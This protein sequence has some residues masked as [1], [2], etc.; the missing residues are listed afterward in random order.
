M[1]NSGDA[2]RQD[3]PGA[4]VLRR[5]LFIE[6]P[7][8]LVRDIGSFHPD[9]AIPIP[10]EMGREV[11]R[12][13]P[14]DL[15]WESMVAGMLRLLAWQPDHERAAYYRAFVKAVR[16]AIL[17]ELS[18]AGIIKARNKDWEIAEEIFRALAGL[19]P[20]APEPLIDLAVMFEDRA[21]AYVAAEKE[22]LAEEMD[23][24]A[25]EV[26]KR[27]LSMEP[28]FAPA[29]FNAAFFFLRKRNYERAKSLFETYAKIGDNEDHVAQ[30]KEIVEKLGR[31]GYLDE[32][33]REAYDLIRLEHE[34]DGLVKAKAFIEK[35]PRVWNGW[36][37]VG[38]ASRRLGRWEDGRAAFEKAIE[39]G[40]EGCDALNELALCLIELGRLDEARVRLERALRLEPENVKIITNLGVL[41]RK[42]GRA[43]EAAGFFRTA[44]EIEPDDVT[45]AKWLKEV[46]AGDGVSD[47][48]YGSEGDDVSEG[49]GEGA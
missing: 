1:E 18:E 39:L 47:G 36:F 44:L 30:A 9:P 42:R 25:F 38:W 33:F 2:L 46:E 11:D 41:A 23:D 14:A 40:A 3:G 12:F 20:E 45:A 27:L 34:E 5:L 7:A 4:A 21:E 48:D 17:S 31:Q 22:A 13:D 29:Y 32:L 6:L 43:A 19:F 24:R 35:N 8:S 49:D 28:P 26:Y 10:V 15:T 16:P 37:L